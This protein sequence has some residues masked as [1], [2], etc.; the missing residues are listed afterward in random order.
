MDSFCDQLDKMA[1][2]ESLE[3]AW[4]TKINGFWYPRGALKG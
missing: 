2:L 1:P 4:Q 3:L